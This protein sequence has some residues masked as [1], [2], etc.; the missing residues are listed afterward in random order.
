MLTTCV[1]AIRATG[2]PPISG[3]YIQQ[4]RTGARH[5][6]TFQNLQA[7]SRY[8]TKPARAGRRDEPDP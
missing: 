6:P 4:L 8:F 1:R 3:A 7:L 2:G 5:N